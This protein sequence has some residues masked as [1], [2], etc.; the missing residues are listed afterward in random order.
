VDP[1]D[2]AELFAMS[3]LV[4]LGEVQGVERG[5]VFAGSASTTDSSPDAS[6]AVETGAAATGGIE[7][8][9]VTVAV[10]QVLRGEDPGPTVL[11]EEEGWLADGRR[12][13]LDGAPPTEV[14]DVGLWF[15]I[16]TG[17]P[18]V[19]A[20]VTVGRFGRWLVRDGVLSGPLL[21][22]PIA[23]DLQDRPVEDVVADL[24]ALVAASST[25]T[26]AP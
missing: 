2:L 19:P 4:I 13:S 21:D 17:D 7:S 24:A 10:Q 3:D 23:I 1:A 6:S 5:R 12:I 18:D 15:L 9:L 8:A 20:W 14:G 16:D 26:L 25:T 11:V 22:E